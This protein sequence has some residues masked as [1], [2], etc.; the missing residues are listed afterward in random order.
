MA[1]E[2]ILHLLSSVSEDI[3]NMV[4]RADGRD[5]NKVHSMV[6]MRAKFSDVCEGMW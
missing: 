3:V 2:G 6:V 4:V 5:Q 1:T